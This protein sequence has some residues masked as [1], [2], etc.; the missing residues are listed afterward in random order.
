MA[1]IPVSTPP[2][3]TA[4]SPRSREL[5]ELLAKVLD[6]YT[7]AHPATT[8]AEIRAAVRMAQMSAGGAQSKVAVGL[9]F[10]L[11]LGVMF[12]VLGLFYFRSAGGGGGEGMEIGPVLP[13]IIMAI[14]ALLGVVMVIAKRM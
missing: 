9:T 10:G 7:K 8:H 1:F 12:L 14:I 11:G 6:E 4:L 13:V 5:A 2:T 3:V